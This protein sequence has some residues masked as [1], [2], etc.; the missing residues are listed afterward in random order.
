MATFVI[1]GFDFGIDSARSM[2]TLNGSKLT[3]KIVGDE[4][5]IANLIK[6]D[7]HPWNWLIQP[8]FIYVTELPCQSDDRESFTYDITEQDLDN[9]DIAL[10]VMEH[11]D[12]LPCRIVK[13]GNTLTI[14]GKVHGIRKTPLDF[15]A[16]ID[17]LHLGATK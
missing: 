17:T 12:I 8:P 5:I 10:Y 9:Y 15:C 4:I 6:D 1:D 13:K 2:A 11:C 16:E 14:A 3:L 7:D